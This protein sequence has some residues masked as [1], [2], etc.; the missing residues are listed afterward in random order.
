MTHFLFICADFCFL[1][2]TCRTWRAAE[3]E[4]GEFEKYARKV[5][6]YLLSKATDIDSD[7]VGYRD[8]ALA[9]KSAESVPSFLEFLQSETV[10][11]NWQ[12]SSSIGEGDESS[13]IGEGH[14]VYIQFRRVDVLPMPRRGSITIKTSPELPRLRAK[15]IGFRVVGGRPLICVLS[16]VDTSNM[17]LSDV[18]IEK[19]SMI[20]QRKTG[21]L[22]NRFM[23]FGRG[24]V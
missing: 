12:T 23:W 4:K 16:G 22:K 14:E 20:Q 5:K 11:E 10:R 19:V 3:Y 13:S 15:V 21:K 6:N 18:I 8:S 7:A 9:K 17:Y 2:W 24:E 1:F